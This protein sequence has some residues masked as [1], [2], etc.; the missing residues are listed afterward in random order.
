MNVV[1]LLNDRPESRSALDWA[2][3]NIPRLAIGEAPC[4]QIV[5]AGAG[6]SPASPNYASPALSSHTREVLD[7]SEMKYHLH[8]TEPDLADQVISLAER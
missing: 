6:D 3:A 8:D 7:H 1:L 4:L 5:I 2:L